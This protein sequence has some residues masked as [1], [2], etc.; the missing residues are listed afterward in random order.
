[1]SL[2]KQIKEKG[3]IDDEEAKSLQDKI[4]S[5]NLKEEE[6]ILNE[7]VVPENF[8]FKLK[9]ENLDI[10]LKEEMP[11]EIDQSILEVIPQ[12]TVNHYKM[13]P[14][15]KE[16]GVLH[17]GMI[18]PEDY[19]AKEALKF[20]S[21]Q[22][23]FDYKV[24]LITFSSFEKIVD[25]YKTIGREIEKTLGKLEQEEVPVAKEG[26][27]K[28]DKKEIQQMAEEAPIS[29]M[30]GVI[31]RHAVEGN[32]SDIHIEPT[33]NKLRIRFRMMGELYSSL[34]L[35]L[36]IHSAVVARVKI[37]ADLKIDE[38]RVPQDGRFS[39]EI[40]NRELD[41]RVSTLPT[42]LGEKVV[43]R[44]LDPEEGLKEFEEL[45]LEGSNF[46]KVKEITKAPYGLVLATGPT[47]SGKTTTLYSILDLLNKE[48]VNIIT[49]EDPVEYFMAGV[50]QS[51][52]KPEIGYTFSQGL[53]HILRQ[54]PDIIMVG[55]IR[56]E[57]TAALAIHAALTGHIV[58]STL[59][60]NNALGIIPRLIDMGVAPYL[61]PPT[62]RLGI[63]QR[64]VRQLCQNCKEK[65][66]PT[67][68]IKNMIKKEIGKL[69]EKTK[70]KRLNNNLDQ[71]VD[72]ADSL[73]SLE[74]IPR[75]RELFD[76]KAKL[77][78]DIFCLTPGEIREIVRREVRGGY[79]YWDSLVDIYPF[80]KLTF[81]PI[82]FIIFCNS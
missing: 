44:V 13:G 40:E 60:T 50:N 36:K 15:K 49:L 74:D 53:R 17:V 11:D 63:A 33:K 41:F 29:K 22:K 48:N 46:D 37:L 38:T 20:L 69:S 42:T 67:E 76:E 10:P 32:A 31:L 51:Q 75:L 65:I 28:K 57:E 25:Q 61:V 45:G 81:N 73:D 26:K 8:L 34:F 68:R 1:M 54:D 66:E 35:P 47:G 55:E 27:P 64:L 14:I 82:K 52:V 39:T 79:I 56:D 12:E 59:H 71:I 5:S 80:L 18:Y 6:V 43:L 23:N 62:L 7:A 77:F 21:R 24:F 9:S 2:I 4:E 3:L 19:K 58:L 78:S 70:R 30:V 16:D 72:E